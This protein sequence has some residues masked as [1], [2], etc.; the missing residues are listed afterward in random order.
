MYPRNE[1]LNLRET[2]TVR[3][4]V[5]RTRNRNIL[6]S[7][8]N[9]VLHI[10]FRKYIYALHIKSNGGDNRKNILSNG[11]V[12]QAFAL[13]FEHLMEFCNENLVDGKYDCVG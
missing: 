7:V 12:H 6:R 2:I 10:K 11:G 4:R 8:L 13:K 9:L 5:A 3:V 1:F